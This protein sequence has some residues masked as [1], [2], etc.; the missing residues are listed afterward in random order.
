ME[1][2]AMVV[3]TTETH[4]E[5]V[6][7]KIRG[8]LTHLA[9]ALDRGDGCSEEVQKA[10]AHIDRTKRDCLK[11]II[12]QKHKAIRGTLWRLEEQDGI[13]P[14]SVHR[15]LSSFEEKRKSAFHAEAR[16]DKKAGKLLY[17]L[18]NEILSFEEYLH[19][20]YIIPGET[21]TRIRRAIR[22]GLRKVRTFVSNLFF[23]YITMASVY[24]LIPDPTAAK[25]IL[26]PWVDPFLPKVLIDVFDRK[27]NLAAENDA[28]ITPK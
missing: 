3:S 16:G 19:G 8:A 26:T 24:L 4:P 28:V 2:Y 14:S 1:V 23:A 5:Q 12:V 9:R 13:L 25:H 18:V 27:K 11:V 22:L 20:A 10:Q 17:S 6:N 15:R 7:N 21:S